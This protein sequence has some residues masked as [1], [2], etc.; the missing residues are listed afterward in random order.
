MPKKKQ[1]KRRKS[2]PDHVMK[3]LEEWDDVFADLI[4]VL[5]YGGKQQV[6]ETDLRAI[7]TVTH[8]KSAEG[9]LRE[10]LRDTCREYI[11]GNVRF[12]IYG[13]ENQDEVCNTM[14][15]RVMG[16]DFAMY[17]WEIRQQ[18]RKNKEAG[19]NINPLKVLPNGQTIEPVITI[20]LY[21]GMEKWDGPKTLHELM[22]VPE[23][24]KEYI[25]DYKIYV[26][27]VA[28]L[29]E[30]QIDSFQS[31]FKY[32]AD[33]FRAKRLGSDTKMRYTKEKWKHVESMLEA[34]RTYSGTRQ[35]ETIRN[36]MKSI[37]AEKGGV[38]MQDFF[39]ARERRGYDKGAAE[40]L[41]SLVRDGILT[42]ENAAKR[43]GGTY[44][45]L[46][47]AASYVTEN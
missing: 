20:V 8:F 23:E 35:F 37:Y 17:D 5:I 33:F 30:E 41:L 43:F 13:L 47:K 14:T 6:K 29:T 44:E 45:E 19:V 16:Y 25:P 12:C 32:L 46:E 42:K 11:R 22:N 38:T 21:F 39:E 34:L 4:N 9:A 24:L 2:K 7:P 10:T 1:Q 36:R 26:V 28:H 27:E 3:Q 31:D 15:V 40:T 18:V